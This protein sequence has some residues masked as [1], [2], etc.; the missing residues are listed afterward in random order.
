MRL[1]DEKS[2]ALSRLVW[3]DR[4]GQVLPVLVLALCAFGGLTFYLNW[5]KSHADPTV[6][7][8]AHTATVLEVKRQ[9]LRNAAVVHVKLDDGREVDAFSSLTTLLPPGAH[10]EIAEAKHASG[11]STYDVTKATGP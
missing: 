4:I 11:K 5:Q 6:S 7:F 10:V 9:S 2:R 8:V 3:R 1:S